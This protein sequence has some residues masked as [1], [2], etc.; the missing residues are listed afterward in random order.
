MTVLTRTR[1]SEL[2]ESRPPWWQVDS[3]ALAISRVAVGIAASIKAL[4]VYGTSS[5]LL[6]GSPYLPALGAFGLRPWMPDSVATGLAFMLMVAG[7][8]LALGPSARFT[9]GIVAS[10]ATALLLFDAR[11]WSNHLF[12][13][14]LLAAVLAASGGGRLREASKR[15]TAPVAL[16]LCTQVSIVYLFAGVSKL[17]AEFLRGD[18]LRQ[19]LHLG[20]LGTVATL[21]RPAVLVLL[22]AG[23]VAT[24][25]GLAIALWFR[26]TRATAVIVGIGLHVALMLA[27]APWI[28]LAVFTLLCVGTYPLFL[29]RG[30]LSSEMGRP[31][32]S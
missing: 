1:P 23:A 16:L 7:L 5:Y 6:E 14:A 20:L 3:S 9:A 28:E 4:I 24:E 17:N 30:D 2:A 25:I 29:R 26:S 31:T 10:T 15:I 19:E 21:Q 12:L 13:L 32:G 18:V 8:I 27:V 22:S 11:F